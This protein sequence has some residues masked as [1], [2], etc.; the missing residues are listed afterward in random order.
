MT[1]AEMLT[2]LDSRELTAW[3]A[4]FE[5][6]ANEDARA[7]KRR[8]DLLESGDGVVVEYGRPRDEDDDDENDEEDDELTDA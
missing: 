8:R 1:R 7:D 5:V 2:R 3:L 6:K 4:L